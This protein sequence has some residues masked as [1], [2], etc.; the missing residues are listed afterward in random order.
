MHKRATRLTDIL[1]KI[2]IKKSYD[3]VGIVIQIMWMGSS[4]KWKKLIAQ[5]IIA[6]LSLH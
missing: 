2:Y 6:H 1:Y 3:S 4:E 5:C